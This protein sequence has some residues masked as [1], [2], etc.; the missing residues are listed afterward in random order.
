M[1]LRNE[2]E[3]LKTT[4]N[5]H[6]VTSGPNLSLSPPCLSSIQ[7]EVQYTRDRWHNSTSLWHLLGL[8]E[9]SN[10]GTAAWIDSGI[11]IGLELRSRPCQ[12]VMEWR[13]A[14]HINGRNDPATSWA[15]IS[16]EGWMVLWRLKCQNFRVKTIYRLV[17]ITWCSS[18]ALR[19]LR[20]NCLTL[21]S[22]DAEP[23]STDLG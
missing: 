2:L 1:L 9:T 20:R 14:M 15:G 5:I 17:L 12:S 11:V 18:P 19:I 7:N 16:K 23:C 13:L 8:W 21:I 10:L 22:E 4:N 3:W 6:F